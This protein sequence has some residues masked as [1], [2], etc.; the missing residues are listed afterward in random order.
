MKF[1]SIILVGPS[2]NLYPLVSK[3]FTMAELPFLGTA[4]ITHTINRI[5]PF[6][7]QIFVF[8]LDIHKKNIYELIKNLKF[9]IE[10]ITTSSYEGFSNCLQ[11]IK[12]RISKENFIFS[13]SDIF[14]TDH[15]NDFIEYYNS[16]NVD[17]LGS[18]YKSFNDNHIMSIT[19][20][21]DLKS[22]NTNDIP[23]SLNEEI[24]VS[25]EFKMKNFFIG[26]SSLLKL[27]PQNAFSFK[28]NAIPL[29]LKNKKYIKLISSNHLQISDIKSYRRQVEIKKMGYLKDSNTTNVKNLLIDKENIIGKNV[30]IHYHCN[31]KETIIM[32]NVIIEEGCII[33]NSIVGKSSRIPKG[34]KLINCNIGAYCNFNEMLDAK[35]RDFSVEL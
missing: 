26:K 5:G 23:F 17:M 32:D 2:P 7:A 11:I 33:H 15:L 30:I 9:P 31:I 29:F 35:N 4:L 10:V 24:L 20:D 8:C 18:Y 34:S 12:N 16:S 1:D 28:N 3:H 14:F 27:I 19:V 13:R 22:Y 25:H 6:S 21:G